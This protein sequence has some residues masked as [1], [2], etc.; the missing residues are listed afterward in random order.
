M[1][2]SA[3]LLRLKCKCV[4][5]DLIRVAQKNVKKLNQQVEAGQKRLREMEEAFEN[6]EKDTKKIKTVRELLDKTIGGQNAIR[7]TLKQAQRTTTEC[8]SF[9]AEYAR[10]QI[11]IAKKASYNVPRGKHS[12]LSKKGKQS[13]W[14]SGTVKKNNK[15][16]H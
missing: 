13:A 9:Y 12:L 1:S 5:E 8:K 11:D 4:S 6:N 2:K 16:K 15:K 7:E 3:P 10:H 14:K